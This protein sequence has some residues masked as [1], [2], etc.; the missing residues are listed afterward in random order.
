MSRNLLAIQKCS[1]NLLQQRPQINVVIFGMMAMMGKVGFASFKVAKSLGLWS[2][3]AGARRSQAY[4]VWSLLKRTL[5]ILSKA[6]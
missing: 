4:F 6:M 3:A 5:Y 2:P 1:I